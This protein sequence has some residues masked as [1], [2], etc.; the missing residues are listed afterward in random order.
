MRTAMFR[1]DFWKDD[2][3]F[4][5]NKDTKDIYICLLTNPE[6]DLTPAFKLSDRMLSTYSG[7]SIEVIQNCRKQLEEKDYIAFVDGYYVICSQ[8]YVEPLT[9]RDSK[10]IFQRDYAKLPQS[11]KQIIQRRKLLSTPVNEDAKSTGTSTSVI[12]IDITIDKDINKEESEESK[13]AKQ[14]ATRLFNWIK[15]NY[16]N[17]EHDP[18]YIANWAI[19]IEKIHRIDKKDWQQIIDV[20][21][22]S[23][24][25]EFWHKNIKSGSKLRAKFN[26]LLD[27]REDDLKPKDRW[28]K[29]VVPYVQYNT[30]PKEKKPQKEV[31][32][33]DT[34]SEAYQKFIEAKKK[35]VVRK[36]VNGKR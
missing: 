12:D 2:G 11:V 13:T 36:Y 24:K 1:T 21:D 26:D 3:I 18:K 6:R 15:K 22:W 17:R 14:L 30:P 4:S 29:P 28:G 9:G 31:K 16:P 23:Q 5:L 8:A 10:K 32:R 7:Y 19:D 35:L 27:Y 20:I 33:A 34:D 25:N